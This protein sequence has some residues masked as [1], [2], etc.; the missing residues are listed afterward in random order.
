[1]A[2]T[3]AE[4]TSGNYKWKVVA[5]ISGSFL[6][7]AMDLN[8][9]LVALPTIAGDYEVDLPTVQWVV[10]ISFLSLNALLLPLGRLSDLAGR[11]RLMLIGLLVTGAGGVLSFLAPGLGWGRC[12]GRGWRRYRRWARRC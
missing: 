4:Q 10:L 7:S 11:K 12:R 8:S 2:S 1:M 3:A 5:V 6:F 9:A